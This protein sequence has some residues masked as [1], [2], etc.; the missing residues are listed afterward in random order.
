ME[1]W[2]WNWTETNDRGG[3]VVYWNGTFSYSFPLTLLLFP[4]RH[5]L[6]RMVILPYFLA[7][8]GRSN[9]PT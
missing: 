9:E 5:C 4:S 8:V 3:I 6:S 2:Q 1:Q 7:L